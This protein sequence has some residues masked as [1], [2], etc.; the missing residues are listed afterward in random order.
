MPN[1]K[2]TT[3]VSQLK[4][5]LLEEHANLK[6]STFCNDY[7]KGYRDALG[8]IANKIDESISPIERKQIEDAY[9]KDREINMTR[10]DKICLKIYSDDYFT[11]TFITD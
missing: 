4:K 11:S 1:N 7:L 8:K 6:D 10:E 2:Q 5:E 3:A 9:E